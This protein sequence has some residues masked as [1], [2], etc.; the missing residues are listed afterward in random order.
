MSIIIQKNLAQ[1]HERTVY[2]IHSIAR[3]IRM[4]YAGICRLVS[5]NGKFDVLFQTTGDII[6]VNRLNI[7]RKP[8]CIREKF[9]YTY[10]MQ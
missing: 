8:M 7:L 6:P 3:K 1:F 9:I 4:Q 10:V 5:G 2:K